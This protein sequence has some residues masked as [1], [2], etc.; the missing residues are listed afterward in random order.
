MVAGV[1]AGLSDHL[2]ID[3][4]VL[5]IGFVVTIVLGGLGVVLYGAFWALVPQR[6]EESGGPASLSSRAQLVGFGALALVMLLIAQVLGFGPGLLWPAAA[7][8]TG[9]A[10]VWRQ[11]DERSRRRWREAAGRGTRGLRTTSGST[12]A[13]YAVGVALLILGMATFLAAHGELTQARRALL[14]LVVVVSGIGL[15]VGPWLLQSWRQLSEERTA[16]IR[17]Q[18]RVELAGRVHDSMLQTLTLIQRR[19]DDAAEVRRLVRRSQ[20]EIRGWLYAD[21]P[22]Q[23]TVR[24]EVTAICAEIEDAYRVTID[25]VVVGDHASTSAAQPMLQAVRE[26]AVN[27]AKHSGETSFSVYVE[28]GAEEISA[29][30]RDRGGGF[31]VD[32]V[33]DDRFGVRESVLA[34]MSRHGGTA[35]IRSTADTGTEVRL[36]L[37]LAGAVTTS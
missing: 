31:D 7:A 17:E 28:I 23:E 19:A 11:A 5:R 25:L 12:A 10:I 15:V 27:A 22:S 33:P 29:F 20:R 8:V 36:T 26:A 35:T 9:A 34:R 18:E 1:A 24:A 16:R 32:A 4:L 14:P 6:D 2:G 13:R 30:V 3:V 37:P 21:T